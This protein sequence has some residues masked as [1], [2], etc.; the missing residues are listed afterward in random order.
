MLTN[1]FFEKPFFSEF[2]NDAIIDKSR[3]NAPE[4]TAVSRQD[5]CLQEKGVTERTVYTNL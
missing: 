4:Q 5:A 2:H 1:M 3:S